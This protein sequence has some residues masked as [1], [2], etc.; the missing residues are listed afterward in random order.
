MLATEGPFL[1]HVELSQQGQMY[2]LIP[3][4]KEPRDLIWRETEPGSG[5]VI[6]VADCYDY[7]TGQLRGSERNRE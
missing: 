5:Q 3:P 6:R 7:E 1:L 4:G 2:P